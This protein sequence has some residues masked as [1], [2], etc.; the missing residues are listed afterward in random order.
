MSTKERSHKT[1]IDTFKSFDSKK[2]YIMKE[3]ANKTMGR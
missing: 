3:Q 2:K 1:L